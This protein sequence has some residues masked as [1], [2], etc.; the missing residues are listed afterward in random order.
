MKKL[1]FLFLVFFLAVSFLGAADYENDFFVGLEFGIENANNANDEGMTPYLM[2]IFIYE[3]SFLKDVLDLYVEL[4][5]TLGFAKKFKQ[6]LFAD[7]VFGYN[8]EFGRASTFSFILQNEFDEILILPRTKGKNI[9]EGILTPAIQ[10]EQEFKFG[11]FFVKA[12]VPITYIQ[13]DKDADAEIGLDF[14]VGLECYFG[15]VLEFKLL[16][17]LSPAEDAGYQGFEAIAGYEFSP[18]YFEVEVV[19]PEDIKDEGVT[20]TPFFEYG[21][22]SW[23]FY[24]ECEVAFLGAAGQV[25]V[26]PAL[27]FK[28]SF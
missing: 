17:L 13:Y 19:V 14:T 7:I 21:F 27:G 25:S 20:I 15:L 1:I 10:F 2:P 11:D 8:L 18:F 12:G 4:N 28:F 24:L 22:K 9:L 16:T 3:A 6:S 5:Y 26:S 23:A